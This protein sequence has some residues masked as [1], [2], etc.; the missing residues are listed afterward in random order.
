ML[1]VPNRAVFGGQKKENWRESLHLV[2]HFESGGQRF[3]GRSDEKPLYSSKR[4]I[5]ALHF[6]AVNL[7]LKQF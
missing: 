2:V 1:S 7:S 5:L 4:Q 6:V 3:L